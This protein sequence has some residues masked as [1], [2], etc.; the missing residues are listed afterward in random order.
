MSHGVFQQYFKVFRR[1]IPEDIIL[2]P[3]YRRRWQ[4]DF[5]Q[6]LS[7]NVSYLCVLM[8]VLFSYQL[9]TTVPKKPLSPITTVEV[10]YKV[11]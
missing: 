8:A 6:G 2:V 10:D 4:N 3:L 11:K 5:S 9:L 1:W 7:T